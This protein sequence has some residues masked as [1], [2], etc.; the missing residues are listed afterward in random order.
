MLPALLAIALPA[1]ARADVVISLNDG[2]SALDAL[3]NLTFTSPVTPDM[4]TVIAGETLVPLKPTPQP[5]T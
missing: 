1:A 4:M 3:G 5:Q 2:H